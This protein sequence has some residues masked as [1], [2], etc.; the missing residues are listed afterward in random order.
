MANVSRKLGRMGHA[1]TQPYAPLQVAAKAIT[2][3]TTSN[4]EPVM[5]CFLLSQRK[6]WAKP[7]IRDSIPSARFI[8][9]TGR[10]DRREAMTYAVATALADRNPYATRQQFG[11]RRLQR[12]PAR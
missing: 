7:T 11:I 1:R 2:S 3:S 5:G 6:P 8:W 12:R 4:S 10:H 9:P